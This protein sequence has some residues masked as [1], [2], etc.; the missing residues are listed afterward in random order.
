VSG[1]QLLAPGTLFGGDF[2]IV[3][4][5][6]EGGMGAVY[7]AEQLSTGKQRAL[8][9]MQPSLVADE[10][11]RQRFAQEARVGALVDS[12]HVIEV[13]GAGVDAPT[14]TPWLAMELLKGE[15]LAER[16]VAGLSRAEL[17]E[18]FTQLAHA[19][20]A[21]HDAGIVHRDLKPENIF[22]A[23]PRR[24]GAPFVVKVLDFGIAKLVAEAQTQHTAAI[25]TPLWMAPEQTE[26]GGVVNAAADVWALGLI[27]FHLLAGRHYWRAASRADASAMTLLREVVLEPLVPASQRAV[28]L[29][30]TE[31]LPPGFDAW[32]A[33]CVARTPQERFPDGRQAL[34][35]LDPVLAE[36]PA[37]SGPVLSSAAVAATLA[38]TPPPRAPTP[39]PTPAFGPPSPKRRAPTPASF[40]PA[41]PPARS[42][43]PWIVGGVVVVGAVVAAV[44]VLGGTKHAAKG[45]AAS[46]N[47][48]NYKGFVPAA[49]AKD[50]ECVRS[51]LMPVAN[52]GK[53]GPAQ[54]KALK[55]ACAA[56]GDT[57]CSQKATSAL[58]GMPASGD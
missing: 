13:V 4:A 30:V 5:L 1:L 24:Q 47:C 21:A 6:S 18:V 11:Q 2:R 48:A 35:A 38:V 33:R 51:M 3:R 44:L 39:A 54:A 8:K 56:L 16:A 43:W 29:G 55:N 52:A 28:E 15:T 27:A 9:I 45:A 25:G 37:T 41:A 12:D 50:H 20:G 31:A 17:R 34:V 7:V 22:L 10:R 58:E 36:G 32:F 40:V 53:L 23:T 42:P 49:K 14:A 26:V 46:T 57:A 19:L